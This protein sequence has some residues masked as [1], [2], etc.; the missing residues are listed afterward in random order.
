VAVVGRAGEGTALPA[1]GLAVAGFVDARGLAVFGLAAA[2]SAVRG[3]AAA[4]LAV[5]GLAAAGLAVRGLAAAG[6]A[7]R[8]LAVA[9]LAARAAGAAG[10]ITGA[11]ASSGLAARLSER[12]CGRLRGSDP[13]TEGVGSSAIAFNDCAPPR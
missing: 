10:S 8:A 11:A 4:G 13:I 5:R 7:V 6:V 3:L 12:R 2:G 9:G 1:A